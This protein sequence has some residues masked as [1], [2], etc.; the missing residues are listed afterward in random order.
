MSAL[1]T[2]AGAILQQST[3][4]L[5]NPVVIPAITGFFGF[6]KKAFGGNKRAQE[7]L[8]M[9]EKME[10]SEQEIEALKVSLD[11]ILYNNDELKKELE[12]HVKKVE[13]KKQEAGITINKT[14]NLNITGNNN[15]LGGQDINDS[16]INI[17]I[18]K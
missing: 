8:E 15:I 7:R 4:L 17:N 1:L 18:G 11:D 9:I 14:S 3:E 12:V 10:A 2:Q 5:K 13:E 6:L 16:N